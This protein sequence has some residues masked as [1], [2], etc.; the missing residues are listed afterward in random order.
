M[1]RR[2]GCLDDVSRVSVCLGL[3][4]VSDQ[5]SDSKKT[6]PRL[7]VGGLLTILMISLLQKEVLDDIY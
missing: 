7:R 2:G 5:I 3:V 1:S 6:G 4:S